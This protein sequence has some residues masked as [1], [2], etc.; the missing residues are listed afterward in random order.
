[1]APDDEPEDRPEE[2]SDEGDASDRSARSDESPDIGGESIDVV[3]ETG[4]G[5]GEPIDVTVG[6]AEEAAS[7]RERLEAEADRA[8]EGF[9]EGIVDLLAWLL[10]TETRARIYV[11]LRQH[12]KSTSDEVAEGTGLY[13]STVREALAE[14]HDEQTVTRDKRESAGAGNNPYE[15]EAIAPSKLVRGVVGNVQKELNTVFNLDRRIGGADE[16]EDVEPV[17]I[18][19]EEDEGPSE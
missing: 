13:P 9:D 16:S 18:T 6:E 7:T 12:P 10:D 11:Y 17:T 1:M 14:L 3:G 5:S 2:S 19:V 15:Y 8:V 4:E